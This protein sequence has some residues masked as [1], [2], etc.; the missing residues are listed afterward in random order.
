M[1]Y[2]NATKARDKKNNK[3]NDRFSP[4]VVLVVAAVLIAAWFLLKAK[5]GD[6]MNPVNIVA[7]TTKVNLKETDG[8][9]NVL[10]LGSD[11]RAD[12]TQTPGLTDTILVASIGKYD[13]DVVLISIPRDLWVKDSQGRF[14]KVNE[15]YITDGIT[16]LMAILNNVLGIQIHYYGMVNFEMFREIINTLGG[17]EVNVDTAFTD[18]E[19]PVEGKENGTDAER[20]QTVHFDAGKQT[21]DGETALKFSRS[22]HGD[23]NEGTDFARARRQQKIIAAIKDKA[24]SIQTIVNPAKLKDLYDIYSKN[25]DTNVDFGVLQNFYL[26]SKQIDFEKV[27]SIVL[28]DR[29]EASAGGLLYNPTDTSLY[30]GRYVLVPRTGDYGQIH[31]YVQKYLFGEK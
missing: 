18:Y 3:S 4:I 6:S 16:E 29:S 14:M 10:I 24:L 9:T 19:Y 11:R 22:R 13:K 23:N 2:T 15:A 1:K 28:D 26:L 21:M 25:V 27:E 5:A 30:G 31:A 20:F 17:V 7:G 8:R 12:G